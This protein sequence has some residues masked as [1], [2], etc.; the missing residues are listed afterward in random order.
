MLPAKAAI[1]RCPHCGGKKNVHQLM[2]GNTFGSTQWSDTKHVAPMFPKV[3]Y[4]QRCPHC[5]KYFF[6]TKDVY[7][8]NADD[9]SSDL[10]ELP[11]QNLKEAFEQLQPSGND[12]TT[13][14]LY[15]LWAFNDLYGNSEI[16]D[17]PTPEWEYHLDNVQHLIPLMSDVLVKAELYREIG[18][19]KKCIELLSTIQQT[20]ALQNIKEMFLEEAN[21]QNRKVFV[22]YGNANRYPITA[23]K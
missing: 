20:P 17:I 1:L 6:Y 11:Y 13:T 3:S 22:L 7:A 16:A 18:D 15:I 10:G 23:G 19:F 9:Y 8:G 14:R 12:E 4:I 21:R 2:S 5:K